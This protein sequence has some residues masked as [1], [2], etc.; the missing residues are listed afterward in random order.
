MGNGEVD[1]Y[2]HWSEL[3]G[4]V[5]RQLTDPNLTPTLTLT[6]SNCHAS[7]ADS[8]DQCPVGPVICPPFASGTDMGRCLPISPNPRV[9][10]GI[11]VR[12][13]VGVRVGVGVGVRFRVRVS[14]GYV[15]MRYVMTR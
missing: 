4:S 2:R 9:R 3:E 8:S 1:P 14:Q 6:G 5:V 15:V 7:A 11:M 10:V 13:R 12:V